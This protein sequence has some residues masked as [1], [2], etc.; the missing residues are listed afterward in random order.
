M[1]GSNA[2]INQGLDIATKDC[3]RTVKR[4]SG[5]GKGRSGYLFGGFFVRTCL[6]VLYRRL[7]RYKGETAVNLIPVF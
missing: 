4:Y 1:S 6:E 3:K 2:M 5:I 7:D